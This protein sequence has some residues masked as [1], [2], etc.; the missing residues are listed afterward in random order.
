M[1]VS[2]RKYD[3]AKDFLRIRDL[4]VHTYD[5]FAQP[6]NWRLERW[7]YARYFVAPMLGAYGVT[8]TSPDTLPDLTNEKSREAIHFWEEAVGVWETAA[9]DIVGV[10]C[11]DEHVAWHPAFAQAH[12]QRHPDYDSLLPEMLDYIESTFIHDKRVRLR[13]YEHDGALLNQAKQR[14]YEKDFKTANHDSQLIIESEPDIRLSKGYRFQ[15]MADAN[16]IEKRRK[17]FGLAFRHPDPK[18]WPTAFSYMQLQKAP[19]YCKNLDLSVVGPDGEYV[20]FC[21]VWFDECNKIATLEPVGS[22][23]LGMGRE[24][25][26]EGVRRATA[27][28]AQSIWVGSGMRFYRSIGFKKRFCTYR[29]V[30]KLSAQ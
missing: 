21:I 4:L 20:S 14:G 15:S 5:R 16:D 11:P 10:V 25:V 30:K 6:V 1:K 19:D 12:I 8:N 23:L 18:D 29:W 27:L 3:H 17:I 2:F 22:V 24:V 26:M 9:H 7:N 28:G 13:I